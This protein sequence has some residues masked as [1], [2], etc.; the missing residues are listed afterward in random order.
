MASLS[1][2]G[3]RSSVFLRTLFDHGLHLRVAVDDLSEPIGLG[4]PSASDLSLGE[5]LSLM[6][7]SD[8]R[9]HLTENFRIQIG[10]SSINGTEPSVLNMADDLIELVGVQPGNSRVF[11]C[12]GCLS[13]VQL[14]LQ[15]GKQLL[16]DGKL[17]LRA[18]LTCDLKGDL[19]IHLHFN[20]L[21]RGKHQ[22]S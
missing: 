21:A 10:F 11:P 14:L 17:G 5:A 16:I 22:G 15:F 8:G 20:C 19:V 13:S 18:C 6:N 3:N 1:R 2:V 9:L 7:F 4:P 12:G